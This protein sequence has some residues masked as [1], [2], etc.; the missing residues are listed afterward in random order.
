MKDLLKMLEEL[1]ALKC[2]SG[3]ESASADE[4]IKIA[5]AYFDS[6]RIDNL[7]SVIF[8]KK[9]NKPNAKKMLIDAHF[10]E[11]GMMVSEIH[12]GGFLSVI[13]IGGLDTRVL[14]ATEVVVHGKEDIYGVITSVPPHLSG[15]DNDSAPAF[16]DIYVDI[17]E[18][19][20]KIS[21]GDTVSYRAKIT[22]LAFNRIAS[23]GL[24]DKSC[25]C[26]ILDMVKNLDKERLA[27][28][29]TVTI[30]AQ[31]EYGKSGPRLVSFED[32]PDIAIVTDV[33]FALG[34]GIDYTESIEIGKGA[35]VDIS[36]STDRCLTR[37]IMRLLEGKNIPF[38]KICE[39][40]RTSTTADG[41]SIAYTGVKTAVLSI[42]LAS[43]H[44]PSEVVALD[45]IKSLSVI[46]NEIVCKEDLV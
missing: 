2:V 14:P 24:D 30:S 12:Q 33:N 25:V 17:G 45:D 37:N 35:G 29:L 13:P 11:V 9:S 26:A 39:P 15:K 5:G 43:M 10:D 23:R 20:D 36:A 4:L 21:V 19:S 38:Q 1:C 6:A 3:R 16:E 40:R 22:P 42:P 44:T 28:D 46:L 41:L 8:T 27:Y 31:E 18:N 7:G 34:E 32:K